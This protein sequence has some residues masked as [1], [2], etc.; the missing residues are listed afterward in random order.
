M[1]R[2]PTSCPSPWQ[3]LTSYG[4]ARGSC[5][6]SQRCTYT[7]LER[8]CS[9][10]A[11]PLINSQ[12]RSRTRAG[13]ARSS[14]WAQS[15]RDGTVSKARQPLGLRLYLSILA[16]VPCGRGPQRSDL[17]PGL[18]R[19]HTRRASSAVGR[20]RNR[21][22]PCHDPMAQLVQ[23]PLAGRT[24]R[25]AH[26]HHQASRTPAD[27]QST[28]R[29]P[30]LHSEAVIS[31]FARCIEDARRLYRRHL[32]SCQVTLH[33]IFGLPWCSETATSPSLAPGDILPL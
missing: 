33:S 6:L 21:R 28:G 30:S 5:S 14:N 23:A 29:S 13:S 26:R 11:V 12:R 18:A 22:R 2:L 16:C 25:P 15:Q 10:S 32:S 17:Q 27:R 24:L 19:D 20:D 1:D 7:P 31:R 4:A 8:K 3:R 9:S